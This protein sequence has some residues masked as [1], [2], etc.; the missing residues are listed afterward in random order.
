MGL[1]L[2]SPAL[3]LLHTPAHPTLTSTRKEQKRVKVGL[4]EHSARPRALLGGQ[5]GPAAPPGSHGAGSIPQASFTMRESNR[6]PKGQ[7]TAP[8]GR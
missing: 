6:Q 2:T 4:Q 1:S 7:A 8:T 5:G 3:R